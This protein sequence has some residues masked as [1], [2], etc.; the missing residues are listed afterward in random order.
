MRYSP[1]RSMMAARIT[2]DLRWFNASFTMQ[3]YDNSAPAYICDHS[4]SV[5][6]K[7]PK[8]RY[9]SSPARQC[10]GKQ[11]IERSPEGTAEWLECLDASRPFRTDSSATDSRH[12]MPGY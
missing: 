9:A 3:S 12:F 5:I 6:C 7:V 8:G 1:T 4:F 10:R 2:S 11:G